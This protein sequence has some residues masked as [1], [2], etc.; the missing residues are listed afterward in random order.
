MEILSV[1]ASTDLVN[2]R[3]SEMPKGATS[4][5]TTVSI[6]GTPRGTAAIYFSEQRITFKPNKAAKEAQ[7][8]W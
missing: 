1:D 5:N 2:L 3:M 7:L 8:A 4:N 6:A